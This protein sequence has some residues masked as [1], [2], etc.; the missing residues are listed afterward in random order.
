VETEATCKN[1]APKIRV[2][3][4]TIAGCLWFAAWLFTIGYLHLSFWKGVF[5][6]VVWPYFIGVHVSALVW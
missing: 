6:L 5:A 3:Q 2:E 4:H 1:F